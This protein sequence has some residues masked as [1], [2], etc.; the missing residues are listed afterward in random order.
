LI[1]EP[2]LDPDG[3]WIAGIESVSRQWEGWCWHWEL[4]LDHVVGLLPLRPGPKGGNW[5]YAALIAL[6]RLGRKDAWELHNSGQLQPQLRAGLER[7]GLKVPQDPKE[8][9]ELIRGFLSEGN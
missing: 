7:H 4:H 1:V 5:K 3:R 2:R 6:K 8:I 9:R